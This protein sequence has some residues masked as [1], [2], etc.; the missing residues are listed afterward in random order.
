MTKPYSQ[1][2]ENNKRFILAVI[3]NYFNDGDRVLEIGSGTAQHVLHF[4]RKMPGVTWLP[5]DTA[6]SFP[7]LLAGLEGEKLDNL[8]EPVELDVRR[9][10]WPLKQVDGVF[11]ANCLHIMAEDAMADFFAGAG[12]ILRP[13]GHICVYGPFKYRGEFTTP[14]NARFDQWLKARDPASGV[15]DFEK[16]DALARQAGLEFIVDHDMPAN[17]QLIVGRAAGTDATPPS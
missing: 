15:R 6:D 3:D 7:T 1:A 14:S 9:R 10:P 4:A 8:E 16:A 12:A 17:N 13:G 5:S 11:S 2:C